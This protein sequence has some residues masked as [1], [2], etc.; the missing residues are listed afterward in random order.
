MTSLG[1]TDE[2]AMV[3]PARK[4]KKSKSK[5]DAGWVVGVDGIRPERSSEWR[6]PTLINIRAFLG[7]EDT[8]DT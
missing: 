7:K 5:E 3:K 2:D 4:K 8:P 1:F 6:R